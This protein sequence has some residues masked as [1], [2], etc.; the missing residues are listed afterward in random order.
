MEK[1][2]EDYNLKE[3][4]HSKRFDPDYDLNRR[5]VIEQPPGNYLI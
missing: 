3:E 1:Y 5:K 2:A 4:P